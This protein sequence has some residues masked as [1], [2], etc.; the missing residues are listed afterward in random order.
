[1]AAPGTDDTA[2]PAEYISLYY[3]VV[4]DSTRHS[5]MGLMD[6]SRTTAPTAVLVMIAAILRAA[7]AAAQ[8]SLRDAFREADRAA[9]GNRI[10]A[11]TS[12]AAQAQALAPLKGILPSVRIEAGYLRTTDPI[13]VFGSSLRQRAVTEANFDPQRLNYPSPVGNYQGG[14]VLEQPL[15]NADAWTGR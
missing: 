1:M 8:L 15:I 5:P 12:A 10:A 2:L 4:V 7:P 13:G 9:Y 11:G 3:H 14:L 6:R